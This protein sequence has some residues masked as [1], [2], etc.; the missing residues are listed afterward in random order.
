MSW[1]LVLM[2]VF[3]MAVIIWM[4][5]QSVK[6]ILQN[7]KQDVDSK[8]DIPSLLPK[9]ETLGPAVKRITGKNITDLKT[10]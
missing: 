3:T 8:Y 9:T 2:I 5:H 7:R 1:Q 6:E 10:L 4:Y